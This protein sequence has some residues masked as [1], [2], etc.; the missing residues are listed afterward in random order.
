MTKLDRFLTSATNDDP[1]TQGGQHNPKQQQQSIVSITDTTESG[2]SAEENIG[3]ESNVS[4]AYIEES[5]SAV[6]TQFT[7]L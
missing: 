4:V 7:K 6:E 5:A 3:T 1:Q 2:I